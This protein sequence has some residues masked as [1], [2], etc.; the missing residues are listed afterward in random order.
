MSTT[1]RF[2]SARRVLAVV[3][4][5]AMGTAGARLHAGPDAARIEFPN[6]QLAELDRFYGG[7]H[8]V[9]THFDARGEVLS[10]AKATEEVAWILDNHALRRTYL[11]KTE[12]R[13]VEVISTITWNEALKQYRGASFDNQS[14]VDKQGRGGP[15]LMSGEWSADTEVFVFNLETVG[16]DGETIRH[17]VVERIL[18]DEERAATIYRM[19]DDGVQKI[20]EAHYKRAVPCPDRLRVIFG[21]G[22]IPG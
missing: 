18:N 9:E 1:L 12:K 20:M 6:T 5:V 8:V 4:A 3:A 15:T 22:F 11:R 19:T 17:R 21:E 10:K 13:V 7:W 16:A 2:V 14:S